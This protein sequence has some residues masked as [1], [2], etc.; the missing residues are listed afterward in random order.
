MSKNSISGRCSLPER[1]VTPRPAPA[2]SP[3]AMKANMAAAYGVRSVAGGVMQ[4]PD[5]MRGMQQ[6]VLDFKFQFFWFFSSKT[7]ISQNIKCYGTVRN[8]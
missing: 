2:T 5:M 4:Q 8:F 3:A 7:K 6:V 1:P